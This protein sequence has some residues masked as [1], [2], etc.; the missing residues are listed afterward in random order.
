[1]CP[2]ARRFVWIKYE[3]E[4][5]GLDST[6]E[7]DQLLVMRKEGN[8]YLNVK[9][10]KHAHFT[11]VKSFPNFHGT[12]NEQ[13]G[14]PLSYIG[15]TA[16]HLGITSKSSVNGVIIILHG[17][18]LF[19]NNV[20]EEL[21]NFHSDVLSKLNELQKVTQGNNEHISIMDIE[22]LAS[23]ILSINIMKEKIFYYKLTRCC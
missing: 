8:T 3:T 15:L 7:L 4:C 6:P 19:I 16:I 20:S 5:F 22:K 10:V 21:K 1:M 13:I 9:A 14:G 23:L 17:C 2:H 11:G 18:A 12:I